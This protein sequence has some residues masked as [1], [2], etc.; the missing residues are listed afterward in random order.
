[1][2]IMK[3]AV[4]PAAGADL[5]VEDVEI[6][7]PRQGEVK[8]RLVAAGICGTDA[9]AMA[10]DLPLPMPCILGHEGA[11][12]VE[13]VAPDV[14]DVA[15]GDH[16]IVLW[17]ASCGRCFYCSIGRPALCDLG[18]RI[19]QTGAMP[20]GETRFRRADGEPIYHFLGASTFADYTVVP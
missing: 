4:L 18:L 1:M 12:V 9:H 17:R 10:G 2:R 20:D 16:V 13:E 14:T 15:C 8:V 7:G 3:A 11:G 6:M 5:H 19:R